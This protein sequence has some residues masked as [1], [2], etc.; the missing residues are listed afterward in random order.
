VNRCHLIEDDSEDDYEEDEDEEDE[1]EDEEDEDGEKEPECTIEQLHQ[2]LQDKGYT[3]MDL[4]SV[5]FDKF[6]RIDPKY[7]KE[8]YKKISEDVMAVEEELTD[9]A[10]KQYDERT[11]MRSE[12]IT[13]AGDVMTLE[14]IPDA[15][16][17]L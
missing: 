14:D 15:N 10:Y 8:H 16:I 13:R 7:T 4:V 1:D 17:S 12:D 2:K 9:E 3:M 5:C 6:S 11:I